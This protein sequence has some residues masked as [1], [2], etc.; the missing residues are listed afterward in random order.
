MFKKGKENMKM[1]REK[2]N[3]NI[4]VEPLEMKNII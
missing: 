1:M 2:K 4:P 3:K